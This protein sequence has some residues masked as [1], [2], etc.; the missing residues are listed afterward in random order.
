MENDPWQ[1]MSVRVKLV[2][3][4][5]FLAFRYI[6]QL[7]YSLSYMLP[8]LQGTNHV[9]IC[10]RDDWKGAARCQ[11]RPHGR[12]LRLTFCNHSA[13]PTILI[14]SYF[15]AVVQAHSMNWVT[16]WNWV[17]RQPARRFER[18]FSHF[19]VVLVESRI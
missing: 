11:L 5:S 9:Q 1:G 3:I 19:V 16:H 13:E 18:N 7:A 10:P 15:L 8:L 2:N 4:Q 6:S 14:G 12:T 17:N